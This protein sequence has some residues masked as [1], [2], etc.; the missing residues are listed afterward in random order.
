MRICLMTF[1]SSSLWIL[2][3]G[4]VWRWGWLHFF[5]IIIYFFCFSSIWDC[6]CGDGSH[7]RAWFWE[8]RCLT[9]SSLPL[10][11]RRS[12]GWPFWKEELFLL[13]CA[14]WKNKYTKLYETKLNCKS[15]YFCLSLSPSQRVQF[16]W[17]QKQTNPNKT[18][19]QTTHS[20]RAE[21]CRKG[22]CVLF[23][24]FC[25]PLFVSWVLF[26]FVPHVGIPRDIVLRLWLLH[27]KT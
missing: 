22:G 19:S 5:I 25:C 18:L 3:R 4:W 6:L 2:Q 10:V 15:G 12:R 20:H 13:V 11:L 9:S 16:F 21:L 24:L 17:K 1:L 14:V 7:L 27:C 26:S 23:P 8:P